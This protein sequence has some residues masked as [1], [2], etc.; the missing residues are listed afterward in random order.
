MKNKKTVKLQLDGLFSLE[1]FEEFQL[2]DLIGGK[3]DLYDQYDV[4]ESMEE[5]SFK[6]KDEHQD[7]L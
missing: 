3:K 6:T 7:D 5:N 1:K 4:N 2:S